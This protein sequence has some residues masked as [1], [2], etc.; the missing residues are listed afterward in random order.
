MRK[1]ATHSSI[2][3]R[4]KA[5]QI[6]ESFAAYRGL[7]CPNSPYLLAANV[8]ADVGVPHQLL[9]LLSMTVAPVTGLRHKLPLVLGNPVLL[10][11]S[12]VSGNI[13]SI[14]YMSHHLHHTSMLERGKVAV[15]R[16]AHARLCLLR[17]LHPIQCQTEQIRGLEG[18]GIIDV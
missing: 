18:R 2:S 7:K 11:S 10:L 12:G 17:A 14:A 13:I 8:C 3:F 6:S 15:L 4:F 1:P 5:L 16:D 9:R